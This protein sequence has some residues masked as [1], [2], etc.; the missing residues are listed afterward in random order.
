MMSESNMIML[1]VVTEQER[2]HQ[3]QTQET[4]IKCIKYVIHK[5]IKAAITLIFLT[6]AD[7]S[8]PHS[9]F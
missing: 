6:E 2:L 4:T 9:N 3:I 5:Q 8:S 7:L 1:Q